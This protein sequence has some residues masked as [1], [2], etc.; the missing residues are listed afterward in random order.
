MLV[1][2]DNSATTKQHKKVTEVMLRYMEEEYG[3][4]SS[5]HRMG[6]GAE[7][8]LKTA[9]RQIAD[10]LGA[11]PA[12]IIFTS[13]GTEADN[14]A[15]LGGAE[16]KKRRGKKIITSVAEHPAVIESVKRLEEKGFSTVYIDVDSEGRV[17]LAQLD[18]E[19]DEETILI[20]I[21]HANNEVGTIQPISEI[22]KKKKNALFHSDCVQSF[23]KIQIPLNGVDL[24]SAS[25]HKI[26]GPK[27]IGFLYLNGGARIKPYLLGGGQEGGM[28]SGT[29]NIPAIA[30]LGE[31]VSLPSNQ[32]PAKLKAYLKEGLLGELKDVKIN[33]PKD[34]LDQILSVSFLGTRAEVLLHTLEQDGIYVS[35]GSAC[36]SNKKGQSH[37]L[38]AMGLNHKEIQGTLRFSFGKENTMEE[39]EYVV[40]K[41]AAAVNKFRK[42][43][44]FR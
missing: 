3:N 2:L 16:A 35:T 41:V 23:G 19:I 34:S 43:G 38:H 13:G 20:S 14:A 18:E 44:S 26:H 10:F 25:G 40:A 21:M 28:R 31:A 22:A 6:M 39:M 33:S 12:E 27:G 42:L 29:E 9:R 11:D 8:A 17:D 30:G 7:K 4:P 36:S 37:V 24:I 1:Y 5:L 32:D 15:I